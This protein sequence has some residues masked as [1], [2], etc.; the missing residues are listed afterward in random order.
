MST[1]KCAEIHRTHP[2]HFIFVAQI[3]SY[4]EHRHNDFRDN[5]TINTLAELLTLSIL[6]SAI[7][8]HTFKN[9]LHLDDEA[10]KE[11]TVGVCFSIHS[12]TLG[13]QLHLVFALFQLCS[14]P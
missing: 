10:Y 11:T 5:S 1:L 13:K 6:R 12:T 4:L 7:A 2:C 3:E 14:H 9:P 8:L